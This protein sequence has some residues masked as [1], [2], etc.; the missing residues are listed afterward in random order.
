MA[1][2]D[3]LTRA[4]S[5]VITAVMIVMPTLNSITG[6]RMQARDE[7][8]IKLNFATISDVH[9]K[10]GESSRVSLL[11]LG[12]NDIDHAATK[13]D[14]LVAAG[15]ITEA[16]EDAEF[17]AFFNAYKSSCPDAYPIIA[18]GNHDTT[19]CKDGLAAAKKR[20]CK[21]YNEVSGR[22]I[23]CVY[24]SKDI[25]GYKFIV[26]GTQGNS[27]TQLYMSEEQFT[28]LDT[29]LK[30]ATTGGK[31]VFVICHEPLNYTHG[32]PSIWPAG[33]VG[34]QSDRLMTML[35]KYKNVFF[36][37]GHLHV[38]LYEKTVENY[39]SLHCINLPC[40]QY[41]NS[42][43]IGTALNGVGLQFEVYSEKVLIRARCYSGS[44]WYNKFS[45]EIPLK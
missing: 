6:Y 7:E 27:G 36:I 3:I 20:F 23:N 5:L 33:H 40:Y 35:K 45:Y 18:T 19:F 2:V 17:K 37:S 31:P 9:I 13:V 4:M 29:R 32:M 22:D 10:T 28:W 30:E 24:Y 39:G 8:N 41:I 25:N 21:Y 44:S 42:K 26:L 15:D 11:R 12:L 43:N 1:L 16:A 14:A 38:G 34:S